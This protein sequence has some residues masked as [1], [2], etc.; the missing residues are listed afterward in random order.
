MTKRITGGILNS[1]VEYSSGETHQSKKRL[2]WNG[3]NLTLDRRILTDDENVSGKDNFDGFRGHFHDQAVL[4][5]LSLYGLSV[6]L[7][8]IRLEITLSVMLIIGMREMK[9]VGST[10]ED[11]LSP[12][13]CN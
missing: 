11:P 9:R 1:K 13:C 12:S 7:N 5:N 3:W 6:S 4:T 8:R 10:W 2:C